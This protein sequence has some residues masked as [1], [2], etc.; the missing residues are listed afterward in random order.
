MI[1][2][3]ISSPATDVRDTNGSKHSKSYKQRTVRHMLN[4]KVHAHACQILVFSLYIYQ[5]KALTVPYGF[6]LLAMDYIQ[7]TMSYPRGRGDRSIVESQYVV[8]AVNCLKFSYNMTGENVGRLNV[9]TVGQDDTASLLWRLA[10]EQG[11]DWKSA[12]APIDAFYG[13]K[14]SLFLV[15]ACLVS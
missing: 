1:R 4:P 9:H 12:Q 2:H 13:F 11:N 14:V 6:I 15:F 8:G 10:G 7:T 5:N 3:F